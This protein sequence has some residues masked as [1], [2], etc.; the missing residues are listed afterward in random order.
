MDFMHKRR[1]MLKESKKFEKQPKKNNKCNFSPSV[2]HLSPP[3]TP[4]THMKTHTHTHIDPPVCEK[5]EKYKNLKI[6]GF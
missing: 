2:Y 6:L 4:H 1:S 3:P 5:E